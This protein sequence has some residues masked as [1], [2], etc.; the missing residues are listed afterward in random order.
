MHYS[1]KL[2]PILRVILDFPLGI[3]FF[4]LELFKKILI[5]T[6]AVD[7]SDLLQMFFHS[8][9]LDNIVLRQSLLLRFITGTKGRYSTFTIGH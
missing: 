1:L 3:L 4:L 7:F 9:I 8:S 2:L 6:G 5:Q